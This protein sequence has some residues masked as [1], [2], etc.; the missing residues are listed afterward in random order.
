MAYTYFSRNGEV[1]PVAQAT[2]PLDD[3]HYAYGFGVYETIRVAR[4]KPR[5]LD[6]H[7]GR[8][9]ESA[10]IIGLEHEFSAGFVAK[11]VEDVII[12]NKVEN[13]NIKILLLGG[14]EATLNILCLNPRYPDR[15]LYKQGAHL[16]TK[17]LERPF[18]HAKTLNMLPSYLAH[19]EAKAAG[20]HDALL[21]NRHGCITES[22]SAN[23]FAITGR[24][25]ISPPETDILL[26]VTR[27]NVLKIAKQNRFKVEEKALKL[28]D[29]KQYENLF[30]TGTSIKIMPVCSVDDR[31]WEEISS[32]L[33]T[34]MQEFD[35]SL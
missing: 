19:R 12:K 13:C 33:R 11:S 7:A 14:P 35:N 3:I 20:A 34:L 28:A 30:L 15:K 32:H 18:P 22:T 27:D 21:V 4:S 6:A 9:M 16:I 10:R 2:V 25:I 17:E 1:L 31:T 24:T 8:L 26:G 29:I 23:V 5:F